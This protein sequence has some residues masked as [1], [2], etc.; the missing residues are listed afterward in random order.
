MLVALVD[1]I[2]KEQQL[3]TYKKS[4]NSFFF[5]I[6]ANH[7]LMNQLLVYNPCNMCSPCDIDVDWQIRVPLV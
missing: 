1:E 7:F 5:S 4:G 6:F 2:Y 3:P